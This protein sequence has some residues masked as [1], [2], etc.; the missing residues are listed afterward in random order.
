MSPCGTCGTPL[1]PGARFCGGCGTS[2]TATA[3]T[4]PLRQAPRAAPVTSQRS[5]P[6][7][8]VRVLYVLPP[9]Y[10]HLE[11]LV[12]EACSDHPHAI[13]LSDDLT[14][15]QAWLGDH[16]G[17][18][19]SITAVCLVGPHELLP[20]ASFD[21][22]T[23]KDDAV[24]T[25]NDWGM[26]GAEG[27]DID[28][29]TSSAIPSLPVTRI[30]T[31]EPDLVRRLLS[32]RAELQPSWSGGL[33][34]TAKVWER[35]SAAVLSGIAPNGTQ[36]LLCS[37][38][39]DAESIRSLLGNGVGRLYFNVHGSDQVPYW[40]GDDGEDQPAVLHPEDMDV[41]PNAILISEACYGAR[42]DEP[43]TI[44]LRFLAAG[45]SAFV[46][47]T[48]IAWGPTAPPNTLAD[49]VP[50]LTYAHLD[51]GARLGDAVHSTR[52]AIYDDVGDDD[53]SPQVVNT[54]SSFVAYGSPLAAVRGVASAPRPVKATSASRESVSAVPA[55]RTRLLPLPN[56]PADPPDVLG[57]IRSGRLGASGPLGEARQRLNAQAER[58]GWRR[59]TKED[60]PS[61]QLPAYVTNATAARAALAELLGSATRSGAL[62]ATLQMVRYATARGE[63]TLLYATETTGMR[64]T[65]AITIDDRGAVSQRV[66]TRGGRYTNRND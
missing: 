42:H 22:E 60:I 11:A 39:H 48:I 52:Q 58:L 19:E 46:G 13:V 51:R 32:V 27:F 8:D 10:A 37:P 66:V 33:T 23:G 20:H 34:V 50:R 35:A 45:G 16:Q 41:A 61:A 49:L 47:S 30:P 12:R 6:Y 53:V 63:R 56:G 57:R 55:G 17:P 5:G 2:A 7:D 54:V 15:V 24:L 31:C 1:A 43:D 21:D 9:S 3:P 18:G 62:P 25:D 29:F 44:A 40:V 64:R 59:I 14:E 4:S 38:E 28:R 36:E 26:I 65:A